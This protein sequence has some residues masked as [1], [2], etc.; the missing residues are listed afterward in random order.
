VRLHADRVDDRVGAT[1]VGHVADDV[2]QLLRGHLVELDRL[3]AT[4]GRPSQPLRDP[5]HHDHLDAANQRD[6][7]GHVADRSGPEDEQRAAGC[8]VGVLHRLPRGRQHVGEEHEPVVRRTVRHLDRKEVGERDAQ[9]L[10]LAAW[11]LAVELAVAE[12]AGPG[13]VLTVLGGLALAVQTLLAHP[14]G[15]TADVEGNDH[16]VAHGE[17]GDVG[18]HLDHGA[19][20]LVADHI[21]LGH[22]G[23]EGVV[24]M[25]VRAAQA[26][27]ADLDDGVGGLLD[28]RVLHVGDLHV[29]AS[30]PGDC[31]HDFLSSIGVVS[32]AAMAAASRSGRTA[33]PA[34]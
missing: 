24:E 27:R 9:E 3:G 19:H 11:H 25:E 28:H 23:C 15:P 8:H 10:G 16:P 4:G 31:S 5:V 21:A 13:A 34:A 33:D 22:E 29:H 6:P 12:Q 30:L 1:T 18:A 20:R 32:R 2:R 14:A 7:G 26:G 17:L